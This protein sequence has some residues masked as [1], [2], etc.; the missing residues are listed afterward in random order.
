MSMFTVTGKVVHVFTQPGAV[1]KETGEVGE[2]TPRLQLMGQMPVPNGETRL[3]M[4]TVKVEDRA[5]FE[6]LKN[7]TIRLPIGAFSPS[8]GQIIY[9]VPKG[10]QPEMVA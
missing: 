4:I 7:K 5:T 6:P 1:N 8:K 9:Y 2:A 10:A 3:D